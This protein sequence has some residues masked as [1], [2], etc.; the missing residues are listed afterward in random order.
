MMITLIKNEIIKLM[1][2]RKTLVVTVMFILLVGFM[3][4]ASYKN[5]ENMKKWNQPETRIQNE[6]ASIEHFNTLKKD[7]SI[8]EAEKK[9]FDEMIKEANLRIEEIKK[10]QVGIKPD[11]RVTL[12]RE[13]KSLEEQ[14]NNSQ[15]G[16]Q[17]KERINTDLMLKK[18]LLAKDIEPEY[19]SYDVT[20]TKYIRDLFSI[21]GAIFLV[22]G[23]IIFSSDMVSGEYTPATMKFLLTQPVS[24]GKVLLSKFIALVLSATIIIVLIELISFLIMGM[25]FSFGNMEYPIAVGTRFV[26]DN[27]VPIEMGRKAMTVVEGS[28]MII[29]MWKYLIQMFLLQVLF[30][31]ASASF[32]FLLS[33]VVK[34]SMVSI[35]ISVVTI[36]VFTIF[37]NIP[38][39]R[40]YA[41]F[42]FTTFGDASTILSGNMA[43]SFNNPS[44]TTVFAVGVMVV[45]SVVS[46]LISHMVF[47]K[48]DILI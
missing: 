27:S 42:I 44:V 43:L 32:A 46:Y 20:A 15:I 26:Y 48:R 5:A 2:R 30:I 45:W 7:T 40:D 3:G 38:Y 12:K 35:A 29:P 9:Q 8:P 6:Q 33:T 21:L 14:A 34:S 39:V 10:E 23:V 18:E 37:Q 22:V 13:V 47:I 16:T 19:N 31:V 28:T 36:I 17:E 11:W 4:F 25:I 1:Q 24:R 41:H